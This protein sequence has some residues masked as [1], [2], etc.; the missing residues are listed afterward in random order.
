MLGGTKWL[1]GAA[2]L[3]AARVMAQTS[4][5]CNPMNATCPVDPALGISNNFVFNTSD[6]VKTSFD[7]TAGRPTYVNDSACEYAR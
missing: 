6:T 2:A 1:L 5:A 3:L 7:I 4:T